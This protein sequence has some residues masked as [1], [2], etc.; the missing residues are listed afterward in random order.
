MEQEVQSLRS[1]AEQV[2]AAV[3]QNGNSVANIKNE[4]ELNSVAELA[5][6][7]LQFAEDMEN[8]LQDNPEAAEKVLRQQGVELADGYYPDIAPLF[9]QNHPDTNRLADLDFVA[10]ELEFATVLIDSKHCDIV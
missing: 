5:E 9:L 6:Q 2:P 10:S 4:R 7:R 1:Q 3:Q 8:R